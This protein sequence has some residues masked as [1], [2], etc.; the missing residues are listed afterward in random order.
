MRAKK[1]DWSGFRYNPS[2]E[3]TVPQKCGV[4]VRFMVSPLDIPEMWRYR[5]ETDD[6]R[7]KLIVEF[8][9]LTASE[10]KRSF[11]KD[12]VKIEIGKNSKRIYSIVIPLPPSNASQENSE[13]KLTIEMAI[14]EIEAWEHEGVLRPAHADVIQNM[15][16]Q[17]KSQGIGE[18]IT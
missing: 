6:R 15:L 2:I 3:T 8:K 14:D 1:I 17:Q 12:D 10:P 9:Y 5:I 4:T 11:M 16:R 7:E 18:T 13:I